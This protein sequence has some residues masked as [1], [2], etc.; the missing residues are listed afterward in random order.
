MK[1]CIVRDS[2]I[3]FNWSTFGKTPR[4]NQTL[5]K[6]S[7]A[8]HLLEDEIV[9]VSGILRGVVV[10]YCRMSFFL[11]GLFRDVVVKSRSGFQWALF[12]LNQ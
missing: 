1:I 10:T 12:V 6:H 3:R 2:V 8:S 11:S 4:I 9:F 5:G 7:V